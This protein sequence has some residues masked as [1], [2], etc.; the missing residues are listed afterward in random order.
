MKKLEENKE[1]F[2]FNLKPTLLT[3]AVEMR[4]VGEINDVINPRADLNHALNF[5]VI[6]VQVRPQEI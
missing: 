3:I 6:T 4:T 1:A 5:F 2:Q